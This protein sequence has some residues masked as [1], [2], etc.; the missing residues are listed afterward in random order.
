MDSH[1]HGHHDHSRCVA[2]ALERADRLCDARRVRLTP[3]RRKV[4]ELVLESHRPAGAYDLLERLG[5]GARRAAPQTVYRAL[6]FLIEQGLVH[7][8]S[9]LN[10]FIGCAGPDLAHAGQFLICGTCR[11]VTE[12]VDPAAFRPL[13]AEAG[14]RGFAVTAVNIELSGLCAACRQGGAAS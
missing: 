2:E 11:E 3:L 14:S 7:R 1:G 4:L 5:D 12:I 6:D 9:S 13:L 8:L 10:A